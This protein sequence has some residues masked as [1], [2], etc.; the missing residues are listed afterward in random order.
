VSQP[1]LLPQ[2]TLPVHYHDNLYYEYTSVSHPFP[3]YQ[4]Q[5]PPITVMTWSPAAYPMAQHSYPI[6][7]G[8]PSVDP[9]CSDHV[10]VGHSDGSCVSEQSVC[11][12]PNPPVQQLSV[13]A[14]HASQQLHSA[15][16][17][18]VH[19]L[20]HPNPSDPAAVS[21]LYT[22]DHVVSAQLN[23]NTIPRMMSDLISCLTAFFSKP[24]EPA[25]LSFLS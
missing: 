23:P 14:Q 19:L 5:N 2:V 10:V 15:G 24:G 6:L 7:V 3:P 17:S 16:S 25:S 8:S 4:K 9:M 18:S 12:V 22:S 1:V 20:G 21:S 11:R 13:H